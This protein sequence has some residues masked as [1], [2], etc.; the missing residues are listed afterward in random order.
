MLAPWLEDIR[1]VDVEK[2]P[3]FT[4]EMYPAGSQVVPES[5]CSGCQF[6]GQHPSCASTQVQSTPAEDHHRLSYADLRTVD[7]V[8][9][10]LSRKARCI[11][12]SQPQYKVNGTS[13]INYADFTTWEIVSA[14]GDMLV[15]RSPGGNPAAVQICQRAIPT[16]LVGHALVSDFGVPQPWDEAEF[17][18]PS[19]LATKRR[20]LVKRVLGIVDDTITL[21]MMQSVQYADCSGDELNPNP[22]HFYVKLWRQ[23][24]DPPQYQ[25]AVER[26]PN[27]PFMCANCKRDWSNGIYNDPVDA[28]LG[29]APDGVDYVWTGSANKTWY[30]RFRKYVAYDVNEDLEVTEE[31][32]VPSMVETFRAGCSQLDCDHYN[33]LDAFSVKDDLSGWMR[34]VWLSCNTVLQQVEAL[35]PTYLAR[36]VGRPSIANLFGAHDCVNPQMLTPNIFS[37]EWGFG[38]VADQ[39]STAGP[40]GQHFTALRGAFYDLD[41]P[42]ANVQW[43][44]GLPPGILPTKCSGWQTKTDPLGITFD[45]NTDPYHGMR[46][47]PHR[48]GTRLAKDVFTRTGRGAATWPKLVSEPVVAGKIDLTATEIQTGARYLAQRYPDGITVDGFPAGLLVNVYPMMQDSKPPVEVVRGVI[49]AATVEEDAIKIEFRNGVHVWSRIV[50][51]EQ[52]NSYIE[53]FS[54]YGGGHIVRPEPGYEVA[55]ILE[56]GT[57]VGAPGDLACIGDLLQIVSGPYATS[58]T[59]ESYRGWVIQKA[60]AF[61]GDPADDWG[62]DATINADIGD[63]V[64]GVPGYYSEGY[65]RCRDAVWVP[66]DAFLE[67]I[68]DDLVENETE[69]AV[70]RN[71]SI[72]HTDVTPQTANPDNGIMT[73]LDPSQYLWRPGTGQLWVHVQ[74]IADWLVESNWRCIR[75]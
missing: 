66:R 11:E 61:G 67:S 2:H 16:D 23:A 40:T 50:V 62:P 44:Q 49:E 57:S 12:G 63:G 5:A 24:G 42:I 34:G 47:H 36:C 6:I 65:G 41:A 70:M 26:Q 29:L 48:C 74:S 8:I 19:C 15:L 59:A 10:G 14:S 1:L 43:G 18:A 64:V 27:Y 38:F 51:V 31:T 7:A 9:H 30:C 4:G 71:V 35:E 52:G 75:I 37:P 68:L 45:D 55:C 20:A 17:L 72:S 32:I 53:S 25:E 21:Q 3:T 13:S 39:S 46:H 22:A 69:L 60:V 54:W 73:T 58:T 56:P 28:A 33:Q